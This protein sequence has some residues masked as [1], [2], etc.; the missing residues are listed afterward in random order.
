MSGSDRA[1]AGRRPAGPSA[2][3]YASKRARISHSG[4]GSRSASKE[5]QTQ[6]QRASKHKSSTSATKT[7]S[8][9]SLTATQRGIARRA[10]AGRE[11]IFLTG[12]AGTGKSYLFAY[13]KQELLKLHPG[14]VKSTF[15]HFF[16]SFHFLIIVVLCVVLLDVP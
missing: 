16:F 4:T 8:K 11:N 2:E 15:S 7:I 10:L 12:P 5:F 13:I 1:P 3:H 9:S 6:Q 14:S